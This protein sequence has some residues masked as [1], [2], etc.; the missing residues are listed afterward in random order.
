MNSFRFVMATAFSVIFFVVTVILMFSALHQFAGVFSGSNTLTEGFI[1]GIN[2]VI[3]A[4]ATFELGLGIN[5]EYR[6]QH[7]ERDVL[8]VLRRTVARFVSIVCVALVLEGLLMVI[9]YSQ[10]DMAGN[11]YYPVAIVVS[12]AFMLA[13]LGVFLNLTRDS[14][15]GMRTLQQQEEPIHTSADNRDEAMTAENPA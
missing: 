2:M 11:L 10:L 14:T 1:Y 3:V 5:E 13:A 12:A 9:K 7:S 15:Q 8:P 6:I 4:L